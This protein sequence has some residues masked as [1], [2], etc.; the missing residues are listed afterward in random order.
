GRPAEL[1]AA[2]RRELDVVDLET[3]RDVRE[4]ERVADE[5]L[6]ALPRRDRLPDRDPE[7]GDDVALLAVRVVE[8]RDVR[9]AV[10]VVLDR[11][12]AGGQAVLVALEVED[13]VH[14]LV[15]AA[16]MAP[17]QVAV[18]VPAAGATDREQQALLRRRARD[19]G[20]VEDVA[21]TAAGRRGSVLLD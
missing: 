21:A 2:A 13:A 15:P 3:D 4:R 19:L 9:R 18:V 5:R 12:D 1:P 16:A 8:Q 14:P 7:R 6:G 17:R 20:V 11:R 10:R